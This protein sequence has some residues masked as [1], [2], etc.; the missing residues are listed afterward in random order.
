MNSKIERIQTI[1]MTT[2]ICINQLKQYRH[3]Y[4]I[5]VF[6]CERCGIGKGLGMGMWLLRVCVELG[7][8]MW[9][10]RVYGYGKGA[11]NK[12]S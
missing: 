10:L 1:I 5:Y 3:S 6:D 2:T 7:M 9:L 4:T 11:M 12:F 8:G